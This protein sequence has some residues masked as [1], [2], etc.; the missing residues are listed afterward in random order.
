[1]LFC[2]CVCCSIVD[3]DEAVYRNS[4]EL[5]PEMTRGE[6]IAA[7]AGDVT[8]D[9][10]Q[11]YGS[12]FELYWRKSASSREGKVFETIV[13]D[14]VNSQVRATDGQIQVIPTAAKGLAT[15]KADLLVVDNTG[16][17]LKRVQA[18]LGAPRVI[19]ALDDFR[20][21]GMDFVTSSEDLR[22]IKKR[23]Q[24]NIVKANRKGVALSQPWVRVQEALDTGK[25]WSK[26]PEGVPLPER[27]FVSRIAREHYESLYRLRLAEMDGI[28]TKTDDVLRNSTREASTKTARTDIVDDAL[29]S[30]A[31]NADS[32]TKLRGVVGKWLG[33]AGICYEV[34]VQGLK[35][36]WTEKNFYEGKVTQKQREIQHARHAGAA[37]G[38]LGGGAGGAVIGG[39]LGTFILPGYGTAIGGV[40]GAVAG[41]IAGEEVMS[42]VAE[43]TVSEL[44]ES[45]STV[46][47][48][49]E[50]VID[51]SQERAR[52]T[53]QEASHLG[54]MIATAATDS[55]NKAK[56]S[57]GVAIDIMAGKAA[58]TVDYAQ[59]HG[60]PLV[61]EVQGQV[62]ATAES[63]F[64]KFEEYWFD[65]TDDSSDE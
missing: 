21:T 3:A 22:E 43:K 20:Y 16:E 40:G 49:A 31:K 30:T 44:H 26:L 52:K 17:V 53:V 11:N 41:A 18:K 13:A 55:F 65:L 9:A 19:A 64:S 29:R 57:A 10:L 23:L 46:L 62:K 34:G 54:G 39:Q 35:S 42:N 12:N 45:G 37:T 1:M 38:G 32:L 56:D 6:L 61:Q 8:Q 14:T 2:A 63:T 27:S 48:I 24:Q 25:I 47:G 50:E 5:L 4:V 33:F 7:T 60:L 36:R 28:A 51:F 58:N 59:Q 15:S